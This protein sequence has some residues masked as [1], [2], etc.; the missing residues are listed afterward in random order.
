METDLASLGDKA[1]KLAAAFAAHRHDA[2]GCDFANSIFA[3]YG[4]VSPLGRAVDRRSYLNSH[5]EMLLG[6]DFSWIGEHHGWWTPYD[7][8][9]RDGVT[10]TQAAKDIHAHALSRRRGSKIPSSPAADRALRAWAAER[11]NLLQQSEALF[12]AALAATKNSELRRWTTYAVKERKAAERLLS[13]LTPTKSETTDHGS[14][15]TTSP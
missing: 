10:P 12:K 14:Q 5:V 4:V 11:L 8:P 3:V 2:A 13:L 7:R 1:Q 9:P 15:R 6:L